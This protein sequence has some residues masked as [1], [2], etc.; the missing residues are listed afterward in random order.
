MLDQ[1]YF[2]DFFDHC[3]DG[4]DKS[5]LRNLSDDLRIFLS[6][7]KETIDVRAFVDLNDLLSH[8]KEE[9]DSRNFKYENNDRRSDTD[10]FFDTREESI[11]WEREWI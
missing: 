6:S 1:K 2:Y 8:I 10:S 4:Y 3:L 9:I 5:F 11:F 7:N